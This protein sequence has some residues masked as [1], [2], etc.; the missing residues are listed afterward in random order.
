MHTVL[1]A[2]RGEIAVRVI[3]ACR[4]AGLR[5]VA[6]YSEADAGALH[7]RL[8]DAAVPLG[9]ADPRESYLNSARLIDAA[10]ESGADAVHP[11]YGFLAESAE[12]AAAVQEA[13]L[14]FIGPPPDVIARLGDK[15][16]ARRLAAACGVPAVPGFDES[17]A[18]D[19]R[20]LEAAGRL[21]FPLIIKA[22]EGGG[23]RGMRLVET[24]DGMPQA[25][26]AARRE[27]QAAFGTGTLL[28]ERYLPEIRHIE[29]QVLADGRGTI[30]A[31][32]ERECS[33]QRRYQK[34]LEEAPSPFVTPALREQL[35]AAAVRVAQAAGY[36]NAGTVEFLVDS[37]GRWYFLEVNTRL[38][39][40]H[41]VTEAVTG[42]D[43]VKAQIRIA[44]GEPLSLGAVGIS[45]HAIEC[46]VLAEDPAQGFSPTPGPVWMLD[47]PAGPGI[48]V[49]SGLRAGWRVPAAY[50]PLL[51]KV[52]VWDR[53]RRE[54]IDRMAE[55]LRRYVILG[56][57]TNL[58]FLQ[59]IISHAA[60]RRG[61]TAVGFLDRYFAGWHP[62]TPDL[63]L[64]AAAAAE[65]IGGSPGAGRGP[66]DP[67]ETVGP[68]RLG[69]GRA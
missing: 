68:W 51:S 28:L 30:L 17:D 37:E 20:L 29:V 27:A 21:G 49:D 39:V 52:I 36:V 47:E 23:G 38:Q 13:G 54:A 55:A 63:A 3:R 15:R 32:G 65:V 50:D 22:A 46:R 58:V 19:E 18:S 35:T 11:G 34:I 7:P 45:G 41:P 10:R 9:P 67:W 57:R 40:E 2:N 48:R 59:E 31:L 24:P 8:A 14:V 60:F 53:T 25:I 5:T 12:F 6:V 62:A 33:L 64:A 26:A 44:A 66:A 4:E 56:C 42:V 16:A 61:D 1:V 43:L 69:A